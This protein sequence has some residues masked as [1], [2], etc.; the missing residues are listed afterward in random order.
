MHLLYQILW[1][2]NRLQVFHS[3]ID[4]YLSIWKKKVLEN[5]I[6]EIDSTEPE[7]NN[8][9]WHCPINLGYKQILC[10][11]YRSRA[12]HASFSPDTA[13]LSTISVSSPPSAPLP[14]CPF[15]PL[16]LELEA[17]QLCWVNLHSF[18]PN[19]GEES[20]ALTFASLE[21]QSCR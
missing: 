6:N 8:I 21:G 15:A 12:G 17:R 3:N 16:T 7:V 10:Y 4:R 19:T 13:S 11:Q 18:Y 20:E 9:V 2:F 1:N 14:L 5:W